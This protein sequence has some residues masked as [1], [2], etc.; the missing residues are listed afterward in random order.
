MEGHD[1]QEPL[2]PPVAS[3]S[4]HKTSRGGQEI[5]LSIFSQ[6]CTQLFLPSLIL[7]LTPNQLLVRALC[8]SA[9]LLHA[10][11]LQKGVLREASKR[12]EQKSRDKQPAGSF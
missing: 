4:L 7:T 11:P 2:P 6:L 5:H 10:A 12:A 3:L 8:P 1:K 9:S